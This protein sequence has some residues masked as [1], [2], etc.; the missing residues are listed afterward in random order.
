MTGSPR[1]EANAPPHNPFRPPLGPSPDG[2]RTLGED[3]TAMWCAAN[4]R[5]KRALVQS[6]A[7]LKS[8][9]R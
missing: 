9:G 2:F 3:H 6:S 7:R 4:W 8:T 5:H 1:R